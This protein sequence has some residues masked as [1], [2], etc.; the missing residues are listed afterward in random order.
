MWTRQ[1]RIK[2]RENTSRITCVYP[3]VQYLSTEKKNKPNAQSVDIMWTGGT[4]KPQAFQL[5]K[6]IWSAH[7]SLS[8][9]ERRKYMHDIAATMQVQ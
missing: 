3:K 5:F 6:N 9:D 7:L 4:A 8:S 1:I 2:K